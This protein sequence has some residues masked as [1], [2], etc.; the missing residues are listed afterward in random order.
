M[1]LGSG[2][3]QGP[4]KASFDKAQSK[5]ETASRASWAAHHEWVRRMESLVTVRS[6]TSTAELC[7]QIIRRGEDAADKGRFPVTDGL[8]GARRGEIHFLFDGPLGQPHEPCGQGGAP[9]QDGAERQPAGQAGGRLAGAVPRAGLARLCG[10]GR[11]GGLL[12]LLGV[13]RHF[14]GGSQ[15]A[16]GVE[17]VGTKD[18]LWACM[19]KTWLEVAPTNERVVEDVDRILVVLD[20]IIAAGGCVVPDEFLRTGRRAVRADGKGMLKNKRRKRQ[21]IATQEARPH[22]PDLNAAYA[23]LVNPDHARNQTF[24]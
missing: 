4:T 1:L 17:H 3:R 5:A 20:K 10:P 14:A 21:K 8:S 2:A 15:A 9:L 11:G 6:G 19:E 18:V 12:L 24:A 7:I 23:L 16:P 22:H 13:G